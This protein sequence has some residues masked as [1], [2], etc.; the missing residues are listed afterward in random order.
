MTPED[1]A[2]QAHS[3]AFEKLCI[4]QEERDTLI[5][6]PFLLRCATLEAVH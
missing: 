2:R 1:S 4:T 6:Q 5:T 3:G